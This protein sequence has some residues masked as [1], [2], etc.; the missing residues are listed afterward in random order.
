MSMVVC[1]LQA[2]SK[3]LT[4]VKKDDDMLVAAKLLAHHRY[5]HLPVIDFVGDSIDQDSRFVGNRSSF[6]LF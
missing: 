2:M 4:C 3:D 5:N 1:D 6:Q